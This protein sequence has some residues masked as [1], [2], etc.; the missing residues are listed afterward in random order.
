[1]R[2]REN[3][4]LGMRTTAQEKARR[5]DKRGEREREKQAA[6]YGEER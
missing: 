6:V 2:M 4:V 3:Q 1:M 5:Q